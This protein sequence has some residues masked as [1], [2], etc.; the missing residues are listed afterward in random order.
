MQWPIYIPHLHESSCLML[1]VLYQSILIQQ[2]VQPLT[3]AI[4]NIKISFTYTDELSWRLVHGLPESVRGWSTRC[5]AALGSPPRDPSQGCL[6]G[7]QEQLPWAQFL[8]RRRRRALAW[9]FRWEY[10]IGMGYLVSLVLSL[11]EHNPCDALTVLTQKPMKLVK[12]LRTGWSSLGSRFVLSSLDLWTGWVKAI[13]QFPGKMLESWPLLHNFV[14]FYSC[15][16][17]HVVF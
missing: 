10:Q 1:S 12:P 3:L 14:H 9:G 2:K 4:Q 16:N 6:P 15:P 13:S 8:P 7:R 11:P 17:I 5:N